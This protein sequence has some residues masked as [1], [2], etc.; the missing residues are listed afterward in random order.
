MRTPVSVSRE[1]WA[2][3]AWSE[4]PGPVI[5]RQYKERSQPYLYRKYVPEGFKP[6]VWGL[7]V[8]G[9]MVKQLPRFRPA[10]LSMQ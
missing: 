3:G 5:F 4:K 2:F 8:L 6:L 7:Q 1:G 9:A 10:S